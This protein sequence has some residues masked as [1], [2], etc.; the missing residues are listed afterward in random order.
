MNEE[1]LI[2]SDYT[3]EDYR[4]LVE[5]ELIEK[6]RIY[7]ITDVESSGAI[8][9]LLISEMKKLEK[10]LKELEVKIQNTEGE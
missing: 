5:D 1:Q 3:W 9:S 2:H 10:Q 7:F 8:I 6:N 4:K